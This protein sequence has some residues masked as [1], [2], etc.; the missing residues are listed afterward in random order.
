[1]AT[2]Y[3]TNARLQMPGT[4]DRFWDTPLNANANMLDSLTAIGSLVVTATETPS[5]TLNVRVT[6]GSYGMANGTIGSFAGAAPLAMPASSTT[7]LWLTDA[8]VL[9]A[10]TAFP[11]TGHVRL[12][13]V[14]SGPT[15]ITQVTDQRVQCG[16]RGS[17]LGFVLKS[18][19]TV[20]GPLLIASPG[21]G[22]AVF[23]A[24]PNQKLI[25][26]FGVGPTTQAPALPPL[27]DATTGTAGATIA[28]VG[29]AFS[30]GALN[31]NFASLTAQVNALIFTL[32]RHG[33]M[34]T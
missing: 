23:A 15:T 19:D 16:T 1:L 12:A 5:A 11:A 22:T 28:N 27:T 6:G 9:T 32:K 25:G 29:T 18:G 4:A 14:V 33:L 8:G 3:T 31:N 17:G 21:S 2:T 13:Q 7:F 26:F 20:N 10:G 24:D 34:S 30:Q